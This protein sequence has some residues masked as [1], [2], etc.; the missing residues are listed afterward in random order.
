ME[1][2]IRVFGRGF[3]GNT[4]A[5]ANWARGSRKLRQTTRRSARPTWTFAP[6]TS[7]IT[8]L[9]YQ[10]EEASYTDDDFIASS[11]PGVRKPTQNIDSCDTGGDN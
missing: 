3:V 8:G 1:D 11:F 6:R 9:R 2:L 10:S 4:K 5:I 7:L